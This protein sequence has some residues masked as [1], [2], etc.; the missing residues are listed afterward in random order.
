MNYY[1]AYGSHLWLKQMKRHCPDSRILGPGVL[2]G[3]RWIITVRGYANVVRSTAD[4]VLGVVYCI[5]TSD[6]ERLDCREG[7]PES[8]YQKTIVA[9]ETGRGRLS[10]LTYVDPEKREGD[11]REEYAERIRQGIRDARLP[12]MYVESYLDKIV[13]CRDVY[14]C[15]S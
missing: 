7:V 5:S 12:S 10:C 1:F 15:A 13:N 4:L 8:S 11:P 14:A 6:E 3:Y 9:V 2:T